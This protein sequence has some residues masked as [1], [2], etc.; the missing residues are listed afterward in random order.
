[1]AEVIDLIKDVLW[2]WQVTAAASVII[3]TIIIIALVIW[4]AMK[5]RYG[6]VIAQKD[7]SI[8][9]YE[10]RLKI[11][12]EKVELADRAKDNVEKQFH[13]YKEEVAAG[14]GYDAL[15]ERVANVEV[16]IEKLSAANNA[17]RSAIGIVGTLAATE[18]GDSLP[19]PPLA[20]QAE[21]DKERAK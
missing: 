20:L 12:A 6:G 18:M 16:A 3:T 17:V 21:A 11:A 9:G 14:G 15:A 5:W 8:A 10:V 13:A 1:M 4:G 19:N 2:G 7:A